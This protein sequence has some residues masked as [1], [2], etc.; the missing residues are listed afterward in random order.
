[1]GRPLMVGSFSG[2]TNARQCTVAKAPDAASVHAKAPDTASVHAE[3]PDAAS[4]RVE[5]L[6]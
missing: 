5:A 4:T 3:A 6:E 2:D 1:M